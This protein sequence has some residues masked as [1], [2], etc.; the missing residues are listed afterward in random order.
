MTEI[1]LEQYMGVMGPIFSKEWRWEI[2]DLHALL[3]SLGYRKHQAVEGRISY[4][5]NRDPPIT[6]SLYLTPEDS[7]EF[8]E[9]TFD[10]FAEPELLSEL[11][12]D[13]M[14]DAYFKKFS[15]VADLAMERLGE[16]KFRNGFGN[17]GFPDDQEAVWLALWLRHDARF[18]VALRHEDR[19]AP[20][21]ICL[22]LAPV[23]V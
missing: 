3:E 9:I 15:R 7:P 2:A 13:D 19:E 1:S 4:S 11:E 21:R 14:V 5:L 10:R 22:C 12:Y 16:P 8:V 23:S 17:P 18:M 6:C 20:F